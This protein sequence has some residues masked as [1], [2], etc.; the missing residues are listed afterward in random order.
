MSSLVE[1]AICLEY[2][3]ATTNV[4]TSFPCGH[5]C[6]LKHTA[7]IMVCHV[8]RARLAPDQLKP[9]FTLRDL[10]VEFMKVTK[11]MEQLLPPTEAGSI[12]TEPMGPIVVF[13]EPLAAE[14]EVMEP[15]STETS[16]EDWTVESIPIERPASD[17]DAVSRVRRTRKRGKKGKATE[18]ADDEIESTALVTPTGPKII[19][20]NVNKHMTIAHFPCVPETAHVLRGFNDVPSLTTDMSTITMHSLS[21]SMRS[22]V[23][24]GWGYMFAAEIVDEPYTMLGKGL[25]LLLVDSYGV[26][27]EAMI[28]LNEFVDVTKWAVGMTAVFPYGYRASV[29]L[30]PGSTYIPPLMVMPV[31]YDHVMVHPLSLQR[32]MEVCNEV[33]S[34]RSPPQCDVCQ[35]CSGAGRAF[36]QKCR[37]VKYCSKECQVAAWPEHRKRCSGESCHLRT[38]AACCADGW[39]SSDA[40]HLFRSAALRSGHGQLGHRR[41]R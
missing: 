39:L 35:H 33:I 34:L 1:C 41:G 14:Q 3:N 30:K 10:A 21:E 5:S 12:T 17:G 7:D 31:R 25:S 4:P 24:D 22:Q 32:F 16:G 23:R 27:G 28:M 20:F 18:P 26:E 11:K 40:R 2:Y 9:N 6:C 8:C 29:R 15:M 36:C 37:V 13:R 38:S 19:S